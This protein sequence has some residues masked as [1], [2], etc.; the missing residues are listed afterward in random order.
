[1]KGN[2]YSES[3]SLAESA[4]D[5]DV[6]SMRFYDAFTDGQAKTH[7]LRLRSE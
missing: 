4:F 3:G 5:G 7:A 2:R 6:T 1:M